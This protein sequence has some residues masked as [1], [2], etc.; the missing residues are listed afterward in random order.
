MNSVPRINAWPAR[1]A[2]NMSELELN[3][4]SRVGWSRW[5]IYQRERFPLFGHG[6][7]V[8][9]FSGCA[10][11]LSAHLRAD[12]LPSLAALATAFVSCLLF[13]AQLR[14]ADEFKDADE[15]NRYRPYRPVPRGLV[16]LRELGWIFVACGTVQLALAWRGPGIQ[17][18]LLLVTWAYL[19]GMCVEFGCRQ[20][21]KQ[22]PA[23]YLWSHMLI[24][25]LV[26][27]YA[28]ACDWA[29]T[30]S[31]PPLGLM[32]FLIASLANG[33]IL[34]LGRKIR[35]PDD[36]EH[37][38]ETYSFLWGRRRATAWWLAA[39]GACFVFALASAAAAGVLWLVA[40]VLSVVALLAVYTSWRFLRS[41]PAGNGKHFEYVSAT[42]TLALYLSLGLGPHVSRL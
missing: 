5:W 42:W 24:M 13:F 39:I 11:S 4:Q 25:P 29:A 14:I 9:A 34:E 41:L 16:T 1:G 40:G 20:W 12:A 33:F 35:A 2:R 28:T 32:P 31:V 18:L 30:S 37:G 7:L 10:V 22:R 17:I 6:I 27:L 38:V 36:E 19:A 26:D 15:D 3:G 8:L 21:L 23:V